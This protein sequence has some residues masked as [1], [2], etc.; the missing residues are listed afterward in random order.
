MT[1]K[2]RGKSK[3]KAGE[4]SNKQIGDGFGLDKR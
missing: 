1:V 4:V 3:M 2:R